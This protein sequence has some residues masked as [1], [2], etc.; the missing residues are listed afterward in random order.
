MCSARPPDAPKL[1]L[2]ALKIGYLE[3]RRLS[4]SAKKYHVLRT[5]DFRNDLP[6]S[7][8]LGVED[9]QAAILLSE[10]LAF[11]DFESLIGSLN[12]YRP[13]RKI[14]ALFSL[15]ISVGALLYK[16]DSYDESQTS[17]AS[18]C[19]TEALRVLS[20]LRTFSK[21]E[22]Q[23]GEDYEGVEQFLLRHQAQ[24]DFN[25]A[26]SALDRVIADLA[27]CSFDLQMLKIM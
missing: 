14:S 24:A 11:T 10:E 21:A 12:P 18:Q 9:F 1:D 23:I 15:C 13:Q 25:N 20:T 6:Q 19:A 5:E 22:I 26:I 17:K 4:H 7:H 2:Y 27:E 16:G 3:V 8:R